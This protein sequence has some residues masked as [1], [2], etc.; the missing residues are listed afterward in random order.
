ML[1]AWVSAATDYSSI[2]FARA[3]TSM[4]G[5]VIVS[6]FLC[7]LARSHSRRILCEPH[8][9]CPMSHVS[10]H[11]FRPGISLTTGRIKVD[12]FVVELLCSHPADPKPTPK[13]LRN[14]RKGPHQVEPCPLMLQI[15]AHTPNGMGFNTWA[16]A[17]YLQALP[18][19]NG[20]V[21]YLV[22]VA[23]HMTRYQYTL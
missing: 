16:A 21:R 22:L 14:K 2:L 4:T 15:P 13:N 9:A 12:G 8:A 23:P 7:G 1:F 10:D 17:E 19:W 11:T 20:T 3:F 18:L 5:S 6:D